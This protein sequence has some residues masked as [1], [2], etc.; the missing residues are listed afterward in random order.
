MSCLVASSPGYVYMAVSVALTASIQNSMWV[1]PLGKPPGSVRGYVQDILARPEQS[2]P[3]P[4]IR[5]SA[6][7]KSGVETDHPRARLQNRAGRC[8]D[9]AETFY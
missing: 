2:G 8:R 7:D 5:L 6:L 1:P 3:V 4:D 9:S